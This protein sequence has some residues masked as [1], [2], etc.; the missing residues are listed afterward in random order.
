MSGHPRL[1]PPEGWRVDLLPLREGTLPVD[2]LQLQGGSFSGFR[3]TML[4]SSPGCKQKV[5]G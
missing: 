4:V 3:G 5:L 2:T 1:Y